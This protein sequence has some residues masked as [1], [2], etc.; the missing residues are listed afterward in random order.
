M[1]IPSHSLFTQTALTIAMTLVAFMVLSMSAA[2]YFV[3]VPLSKRYADDFAA[4]IVS[5]AHSLQSLPENMHAELR[6]QLLLDHGII[7]AEETGELSSGSE[8]VIYQTY[9][10]DALA[11]RAGQDLAIYES[12]TSSLIW[13]DV[14]AHGKLFRLGFDGKRLRVQLPI[15][16]LLALVAGAL[17]TLAASLMEVRRVVEPLDHLSDMAKK[18]GRGLR[19]E[20]VPEEGPEEIAALAAAFNQMSADLR[21]M[22]ENRTVMI[23]GLSHDLRTPLTR[24]S[25]AVEMLNEEA[26]GDLVRRIRRDLDT[27]NN[28]IGQ[29]VQFSQG[30]EDEC[31]VQLDL[32]QIL[33]SLANDLRIEG[34]VLHLHRN[35]P[36]CVYYADPIALERVLTN[37]MR[38]AVHYGD[39][40]PID[41]TLHCAASGVSIEISDRGPG[42]PPDQVDA[43]F[44]P[45][46]R[47]EIARNT[48]TGGS[49]LGLAIAQQ[50]AVKHG[51]T[52]R[53]LPREGGGTI[54]RL[55]LPVANRFG[56]RLSSCAA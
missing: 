53:L 37:L 31:P 44:R 6:R 15:V 38:N 35:D 14:P 11:R 9:F 23:A 42:I 7:V 18:V 55:E 5:A 34:A 13:V 16:L 41:V 56:L 36:P 43:V 46:H 20:R 51:W 50:L 27:M 33:G 17:L 21:Q 19:P 32:R 48:R 8:D 25:L 12:G 49:G 29:F 40:E 3:Y 24:L 1:R 47:L 45:F 2:A 4:V 26:D 28:L 39:G 30:I 52:I 22:S 54:A 10:H